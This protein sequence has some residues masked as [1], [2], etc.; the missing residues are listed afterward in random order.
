MITVSIVEDHQ[1]IREGLRTL[2]DNAEGYQ[3][4]GAYRTMEAALEGLAGNPSHVIL[5]DLGLPG[6]SGIDGIREIR[7]RWPAIS[8][9]VLT[10]F[11]D[12]ARIFQAICAGAAG[13]LL[14]KTPPS[15]LLQSIGEV[16]IG[17]APMS[18]DVARR[19]LHL[20]REFRPPEVAHALTPHELRLLKLMVQGHN[21]QTASAELGVTT[22]T[23]SYHMRK[24][25]QKLEVHS[26]ADAVSKAL[27]D[28]IIC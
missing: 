13:Y 14:K 19:V 11:E 7:A 26:K 6:M 28:R 17:G 10:V 8:P 25:Y 22:H 12:D 1:E 2:V 5:V 20:F 9:I 18:P 3:C 23:I 4:I 21:Y 16:A 15:K 27:R 24:I